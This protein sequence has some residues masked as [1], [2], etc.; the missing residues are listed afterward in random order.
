MGA[1]RLALYRA[2]TRSRTSL[3][4][5]PFRTRKRGSSCRYWQRPAADVTYVPLDTLRHSP[6]TTVHQPVKLLTPTGGGL[7]GGPGICLCW[8]E[9]SSDAPV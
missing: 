5:S 9:A 8:L 7:P 2:Y 4:R 1:E 3:P 6:G